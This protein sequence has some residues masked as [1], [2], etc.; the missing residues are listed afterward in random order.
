MKLYNYYFIKFDKKIFM[1][2]F[3][4]ELKKNFH[5]V[6]ITFNKTIKIKKYTE[7]DYYFQN[8]T[9]DVV[10][11]DQDKNI[12]FFGFVSDVSLEM[13][14]NENNNFYD[15]VNDFEDDVFLFFIT[16]RKV[17]RLKYYRNVC[18]IPI[19]EMDEF[20]NEIKNNFPST[21]NEIE[22]LQFE[23]SSLKNQF[24]SEKSELLNEN[25]I[26]VEGQ[27]KN[28]QKLEGDLRYYQEKLKDKELEIISLKKYNS[29]VSD[30]ILFR[31]KKYQ[32]KNNFLEISTKIIRPEENYFYDEIRTPTGIYKSISTINN[33]TTEDYFTIFKNKIYFRMKIYDYYSK[34]RIDLPETIYSHSFYYYF[35]V[36][37]NEFIKDEEID[38]NFWVEEEKLS[39]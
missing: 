19:F 17:L 3:F 26:L 10:F 30:D 21:R 4:K 28:I 2:N 12:L 11:K 7:I 15:F 9:F 14:L 18:E 16:E 22:N 6:S 32:N 27:N 5:K 25:R 29:F 33:Y 31:L 8:Y 39:K 13:F 1:E 38:F 24:K 20:S 37:N 36:E 35:N 34:G 23:I